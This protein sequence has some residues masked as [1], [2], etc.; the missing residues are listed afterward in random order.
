[1][2]TGATAGPH[3]GWAD[4]VAGERLKRCHDMSQ[5]GAIAMKARAKKIF[6]RAVRPGRGSR[7]SNQIYK[8]R[9]KVMKPLNARK[10]G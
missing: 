3:D 7:R 2:N 4:C 5:G 8:D 1:M 9:A 10:S 6:G